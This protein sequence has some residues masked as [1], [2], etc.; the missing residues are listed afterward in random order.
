[1]TI[2][3]VI[4]LATARFVTIE[5]AASLT[6]LTAKAIRRKMERGIWLEGRHYRKADGRIYIDL[7]AYEAWVIGKR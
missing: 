4:T 5:L 1:M 3:P 7:R 6:G 2:E